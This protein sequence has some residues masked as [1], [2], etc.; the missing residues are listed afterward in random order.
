[1]AE[2]QNLLGYR[3]LWAKLRLH[4]N[5]FQ[6]IADYYYLPL[7]S[8]VTSLNYIYRTAKCMNN[9]IARKSFWKNAPSSVIINFKKWTREET[10]YLNE[11]IIDGKS[12]NIQ[13]A[14]NEEWKFCNMHF[15]N[16]KNAH[17]IC[18]CTAEIHLTV[19]TWHW[20]HFMWFEVRY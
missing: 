3:W 11:R 5:L 13:R 19:A 10:C 17:F 12:D 16:C 7:T 18:S 9:N 6:F 14:P 2:E 4:S 15:V 1:M 20:F 8:L